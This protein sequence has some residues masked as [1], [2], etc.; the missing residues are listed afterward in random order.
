[1]WRGSNRAN[2]PVGDAPEEER[3]AVIQNFIIRLAEMPHE[4]RSEVIRQWVLSLSSLDAALLY[5]L[6]GGLVHRDDLEED[7]IVNRVREWLD[8]KSKEKR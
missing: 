1:M 8:L 6:L 2:L 4:E 3:G 7:Y 5:S